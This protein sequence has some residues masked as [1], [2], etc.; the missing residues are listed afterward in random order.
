MYIYTS[1]ISQHSSPSPITYPPSPLF[2]FP[3][4]EKYWGQVIKTQIPMVEDFW[5]LG[6]VLSFLRAGL[7]VFLFSFFFLSFQ[8]FCGGVWVLEWCF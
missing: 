5:E 6:L 7:W 1:F 4:T 2:P 3:T 8:V